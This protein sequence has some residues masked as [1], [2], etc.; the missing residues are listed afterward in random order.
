MKQL[1]HI[2][3]NTNASGQQV[4]SIRL[5]EKHGCFAIS[6]KSGSELYELAYCSAD[7]WDEKELSN[8]L[9]AYP[10]LTN[11]FYECQVAYDFPDGL[12]VPAAVYKQEE[13]TLLLNGDNNSGEN[14]ITEQVSGWQFNTIYAV[15]KEIQQWLSQKFPAAKYRH[16]YSLEIRTIHTIREGGMLLVDFRKDDLTVMVAGGGKFLLAQCFPYSTPDDVLYY[17]LKICRQFSLSQQEVVV[18]LSGLVDKQ[19]SLY[20][21]LYQYFIH[22]AFR[23]ADWE[24]G[25]EYP[26]HFFT[27]LNDL[28]KCAS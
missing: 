5:G 15:P 19:S 22:I 21:E 7:R 12:F 14:I 8:W 10:S 16:Q 25:S 24:A 18:E 28:A 23:D 3:Q 20:R 2:S 6:N 26:A 4:L 1:F 11:S 9:A 17:L 27:T 13:A